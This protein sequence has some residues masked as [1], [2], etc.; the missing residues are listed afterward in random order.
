MEV[1]VDGATPTALVVEDDDDVCEIICDVLAETG[2]H[3]HTAATGW[4]A[5]AAIEERS[6]DILIVDIGLPGGLDGLELAQNARL[7]HPALKC[8]FIS[9]QRAPIVCDPRLDDFI[10]KPFRPFE[11]VG[12][13][14][15]VLRGN[16]PQP[17][18]EIA[19]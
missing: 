17:R 16:Y 1:A 6:F 18:L 19:R 10:S 3:I 12:C 13:V 9:G 7:R 5:L 14:W 8:L 11:L 4:E 15:K 2:F